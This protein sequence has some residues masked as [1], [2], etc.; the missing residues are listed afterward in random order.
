MSSSRVVTA[1][2]DPYVDVEAAF[3]G[4]LTAPTPSMGARSDGVCLFYADAVNIVFGDPET[5]KT[6]L[7][8]HVAAS[9][10]QNGGRVLW[11]DLDHNGAS[12]TLSGLEH[13]GA[14]RAALVDR[15]RFRLALPEDPEAFSLVVS[16]APTWS[17]TLV[18]V[19]SVGELLPLYGVSSNDADEFTRVN[20]LT[21]AALAST[22]A[23]VVAIDHTAKNADSRQY[24]S[25]G[26]AAKKRSVSGSMLRVALIEPFSPGHG[27]KAVLKVVKDRHGGLRAASP[28]GDREPAAAVFT[29][30]R[31]GRGALLAPKGDDVDV[32]VTDVELL[33]TL[34]PPPTSV[35]DVK[36]RM[37]WRSERAS[38]AL[39]AWRDVP[40]SPGTLGEQG[41]TDQ[42]GVFPVP[43]PYRG[44]QGNAPTV[45]VIR[46]LVCN[47][48]LD[49]RIAHQGTHPTC[50]VEAMGATA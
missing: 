6:L 44:E 3:A 38:A 25:T 27:G 34:V 47:E 21:L 18:V 37:H 19:D 9:E 49:A 43:H 22:G 23:A 36:A 50:D 35:R 16:D 41:T 14:D 26:T 1:V 11:L 10:L 2:D 42:G 5:G 46:C 30:D 7:T 29:L 48:P 13:A 40:R 17:P 8:R 45:A 20:R 33:D 31:F 12:A 32:L 28:I 39:A 24:G 15:S 4:N